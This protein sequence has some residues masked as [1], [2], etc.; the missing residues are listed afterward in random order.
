MC[1]VA[2]QRGVQL[3]ESRDDLERA[4]SWQKAADKIHAEVCKKG[5]DG[6][7][8]F[9]QYY[10]ADALDASLLL[11]PIM[12]FLPADDER[13]RATVLAIADHLTK[14][15]LVLRYKVDTT[16]DGLSGE[17][18]TFTICSF[19]L[20]SALATIGETERARALF[21]KLLSF[22]GPLLLYAE[23][24]DTSTGQHLG[25]YPQAF[26]HLALIDAANRL[27]AAEPDE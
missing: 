16:D 21:E 18:G 2:A 14:D 17:E 8:I 19:W 22:A 27:I 26:T 6:R 13:V 4:E 3:A 25:N 24:I 15:G 23:E 20:V 10:G 12:G 9:T 11:I 1:W 7:G 5:V